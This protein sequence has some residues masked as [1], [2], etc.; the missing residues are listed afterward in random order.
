MP[1]RNLLTENRARIWAQAH[2]ED[3]GAGIPMR[4][5]IADMDGTLALMGEREPYGFGPDEVLNDK[6][7]QDV[8]DVVLAMWLAGHIVIITSGR[9]ESCREQTVTWLEQ[10]CKFQPALLLMRPTGD[11]RKDAIVK[12]EM[13]EN[14]IQPFYHVTAVFDDRNQVVDMWRAMGLTCLQVAPGDF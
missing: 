12:R 1:K 9:Q 4:A 7:N 10:H 6:P 3:I 11:N 2:P 14:E 8:I 5:V 13:F